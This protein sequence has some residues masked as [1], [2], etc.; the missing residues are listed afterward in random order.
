M[1]VELKLDCIRRM[2]RVMRKKMR[3]TVGSKIDEEIVLRQARA[4]TT[5]YFMSTHLCAVATSE[6]EVAIVEL[7]RSYEY[8]FVY[9]LLF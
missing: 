7:I 9:H 5:A 3:P 8:V 6:Y 1:L 4:R 2:T